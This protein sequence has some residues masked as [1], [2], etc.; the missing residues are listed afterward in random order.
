M[1]FRNDL[2]E[3]FLEMTA[4]RA[5]TAEIGSWYLHIRKIKVA[6]ELTVKGIVIFIA[7]QSEYSKRATILSDKLGKITAFAQGA[8]KI[9]SRLIG[10]LRPMTAAV[11]RIS[12]GRSAYNIHGAEL[13]DPFLEL[14]RDPEDSFYGTYFL[15]MADYFAQEGMVEEEAKSMLNLL[16]LSLDALRKGQLD[17]RL[18]RAVYELRL[19]VTEGE[20]TEAPKRGPKE[21]HELWRHVVSSPLSKLFDRE[22][23]EDSELCSLFS[24]EAI[25]MSKEMCRHEFRSRRLL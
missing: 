12:K 20:Y 13:I 18:I 7:P 23:Y 25:A 15:E 5:G 10:K 14:S 24:D 22:H 1:S 11:F 3:I 19:L 9:N 2:R 8:A 6:E 17:R 16:F 4:G 21:L